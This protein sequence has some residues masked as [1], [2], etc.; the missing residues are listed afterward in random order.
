MGNGPR[1]GPLTLLSA[2]MFSAPLLLTVAYCLVPF[3]LMIAEPNAAPS[4][5]GEVAIFGGICSTIP[6][7]LFM[8]EYRAIRG[9][10][11]R[12]TACV[13]VPCLGLT[14]LGPIRGVGGLLSL[15]G[16]FAPDR[17]FPSWQEFAFYSAFVACLGFIGSEHWKWY[18]VLR[19][20][21]GVET[22]ACD[23]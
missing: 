7:A 4:K 1:P 5:L 23:A 6:G 11:P 2:A 19:A 14:A 9:K 22:P 8:V 20:S 3:V 21:K 13:A 16:L 17:E 12:A 18:C 15:V 10:S